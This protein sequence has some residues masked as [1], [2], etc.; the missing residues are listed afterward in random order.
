MKRKQ[1]RKVKLRPKLSFLN[2]YHSL[3]ADFMVQLWSAVL[4]FYSERFSTTFH[5]SS[6]SLSHWNK[7][8]F[9][10]DHLTGRVSYHSELCC[11]SPN[12]NTLEFHLILKSQQKSLS[13]SKILLLWLMLCV[14]GTMF[15]SP[16]TH[17]GRSM[18]DNSK[19]KM[20]YQETVMD[21]VTYIHTYSK[22]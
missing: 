22:H 6:L 1:R 5:M 20:I 19:E 10:S 7:P 2:I 12:W 8:S 11:G 15:G 4:Q 18:E 16:H 17:T 14:M 21:K 3:P 9:L 13:I